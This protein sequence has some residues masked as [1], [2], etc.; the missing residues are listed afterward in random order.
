MK[1]KRKFLH[2]LFAIRKSV[3]ILSLAILLV[4]ISYVL[5]S[6]NDQ[7]EIVSFAVGITASVIATLV[8]KISDKYEKSISAC[9]DISNTIEEMVLYLERMVTRGC[10]NYE[11]C[12]TLWLYYS[13]IC[14]KSANLTYEDEFNEVTVIINDLIKLVKENAD[15]K[16]LYDAKEKLVS[17]KRLFQ[18]V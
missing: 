2:L 9:V 5:I 8:F 10:A 7:N 13:S 4:V 3:G 15:L 16:M 18:F 6:T 11:Y 1:Y 12:S 14:R 17:A